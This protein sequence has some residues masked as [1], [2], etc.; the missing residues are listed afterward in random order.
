MPVSLKDRACIT[1]IGET[2]YSRGGP[3][4]ERSLLSLQL[5]AATKAIADASLKSKDV[6]AILPSQYGRTAEELATNLGIEELRY[7]VT[8]YMGGASPVACLQTAALAIAAGVATNVL[9]VTGFNFYSSRRVQAL[10]ADASSAMPMS[11]IA[12]D[13]YVPY[14]IAVPAQW[15]S[16]IARRHMHEFGTTPEQLGAVAVAMRKHAQL[17][18]KALMRGKEMTL[19]DYLAS[20]ILFGPYRLLDCCLETDGAAAVVVT[21][22]ERAQDARKKPVSISGVATGH[23]YPA[24]DITN[25]KDIF[26]IGLTR[27][28]PRAFAM[29]GVEHKDIDFAQVYDC[30]TFEA[31]QQIEEMGFCKRGEGGAFVEGGRIEL[32]G[33]LPVNTHGGLLAEAHTL[34]MNHIIE[35]TRQLRGQ[36]GQRQ[37]I[38]ARVGLV[39]GWGDFGDGSIA[40]LRN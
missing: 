1:G 17:N 27:A 2:Q 32:G 30:F 25:R 13:Y 34:G 26:E 10:S 38:G 6:D 29:A 39:T 31:L 11:W 21:A 22:A 36:A 4:S 8:V 33:D 3:N 5:E 24:D 15:Y 35:A 40:I 16:L 19:D 7:A 12:N 18:E 9:I 20:P 14:G 28:A 37:I 23:P